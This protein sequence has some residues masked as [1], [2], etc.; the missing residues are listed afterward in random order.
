MVKLFHDWKH[1]KD[2]FSRPGSWVFCVRASTVLSFLLSLSGFC[3]WVPLWSRNFQRKLLKIKRIPCAEFVAQ[4]SNPHT[5]ETRQCKS[6]FRASLVYTE[7]RRGKMEVAGGPRLTCKGSIWIDNS[8]TKLI[9]QSGF[10]KC[11]RLL[12]LCC[13]FYVPPHM[14]T[15]MSNSLKDF[16]Q[17]KP[18]VTPITKGRKE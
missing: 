8:S 9:K 17:N 1:L 13:F 10:P 11:S 14:K 12:T 15:R 7:G 6:E 16:L 4:A 3:R 5:R 18:T 2:A